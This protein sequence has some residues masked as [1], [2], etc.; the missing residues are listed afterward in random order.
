[1]VTLDREGARSAAEASEKRW[2]ERAPFGPLDGVPLTVKDNIPVTRFANHLGEQT[3]RRLCARSRRIAHCQ[4]SRRR[5]DHSWQNQL[6]GIHSSG[7][8]R[9]SGLWANSKPVEPGIDSRRLER[10]SRR[11]GFGGHRS[12]RH[13]HRWRRL[14]SSTGFTHRSCWSEAVP[15]PGSTMRRLSGDPAPPRNARSD[16]ANGCGLM[17]RHAGHQSAGPAR[18]GLLLFSSGSL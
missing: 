10:R 12:D 1:M 11:S 9:Q 5:G 4:A 14:N 16:D 2:L 13:R 7:L 6:P 17:R 15:G 18:S 8:H 3:L